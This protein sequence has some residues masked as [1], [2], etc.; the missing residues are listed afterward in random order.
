MEK[1]VIFSS[2]VRDIYNVIQHYFC[3]FLYVPASVSQ[4]CKLGPCLLLLKSLF[5][6]F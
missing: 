5:P 6:F 1:D 3:T 2:G 4:S